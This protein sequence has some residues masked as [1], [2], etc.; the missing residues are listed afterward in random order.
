MVKTKFSVEEMKSSGIT[1]DQSR[2]QL[3]IF[4]PNELIGKKPPNDFY[5]ISKQFK[6]PLVLVLLTA[7]IVTII[8]GDFT[9]AFVIFLAI[10]VNTLLGFVQERKAFKSLDSLKKVVSHE[11]WVIRKDDNEKIGKK[12]QI[13]IS[14]IVPGD[15]VVLYEGDKVPADG[16]I[17]ENNDL[18]IDEAILTGESISVSKKT[19]VNNIKEENLE[20][21]IKS[22]AKDNEKNSQSLLMGTT[23]IGGSG[24][25]IVTKTGMNTEIG[26]IATHLEEN[27]ESKTPL[28]KKLDNLA[29][30]ITIGIVFLSI[31]IFITG[32][33][34]KK[35]PTEMFKTAVALAVAAIP[36]GL[37]VGLTAIL[38][39]GMHRILKRKGLVKSLVAA[40]TLGS[41]TTVCVDK[42]GTLTEGKMKVVETRLENDVLAY[43]ASCFAND[44]KDP[45]EIARWQWAHEVSKNNLIGDNR[46]KLVDPDELLELEPR[47]QNIPFSVE[48]RFLASRHGINIYLAG[49]P[50]EMIARSNINSSKADEYQKL[51]EDWASKG[52]RL[53]GFAYI[54][55][56]S[57]EEAKEVFALLKEEKVNKKLINW[58]GLMAFDDPIRKSVKNTIDRTLQAGIKVKVIT[59][60]YRIT[61]VAVM[62]KIGF[63]IKNDQII[64]GDELEK[65]SDAQLQKRVKTTLLFSRTKPSQKLRIVKALQ[66][67]GEIVGMMGDGINDAPALAI[68]DIGIVVE[69][70]SEI[71]KEASDLILLDSNMETITASIEEGR[72]ML[73]NLKKVAMYLLSDSFSEIIIV[74]VSLL[75]G[76]PIAITAVQILWINLVDDGLPNLALTID[77]KDSGLL[78]RKPLKSD[79]KLINGEMLGLIILISV[80]TAA[81]CLLVFWID[82]QNRGLE[83]ARTMVFATLSIDS[84]VYVFSCRSLTKNIWQESI[85]KNKWLII[86]SLFG[87]IATVLSVHLRPLQI[88]LGTTS[89]TL[90]DW[91]IV[92]GVSM[93]V[94][95][96]I[97]LFKFIYN[98]INLKK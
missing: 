76:W 91:L 26:K 72:S 52:R 85:F 97:E 2:K 45:I 50:E 31:F 81:S 46:I 30:N 44:L 18:L 38:A 17:I 35:D 39:I 82:W 75:L 41:V 96:T 1:N 23:V 51:I 14:Q 55:C 80:V 83:L 65:M 69:D 21:F 3:E 93:G 12:I 79:A 68:A 53:I 8:V 66:S 88:L 71:A 16:I 5:F 49:A 77:P 7:T 62:E 19:V 43:K 95:T 4:G 86:A 74:L 61:A 59:G 40:E 15:V 67:N 24:K 34:L 58:L 20:N 28:E 98:K 29:K 37:V 9:D 70:A 10:I 13:A 87:I 22:L 60:D 42:T 89:L 48:K 78:K 54:Q 92:F 6:N 25:I 32:V 63:K 64:E 11:A 73:E 36:E 47:D 56:K 94:L 90:M 84:L 57:K 33:V 27:Q